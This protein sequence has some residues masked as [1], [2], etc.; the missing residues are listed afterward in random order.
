METSFSS[1]VAAA[2]EEEDVAAEADIEIEDSPEI[3]TESGN[4]KQ[5]AESS[6]RLD[7]EEKPDVDTSSLLGESE[8]E[9]PSPS[10]NSGK[11][12]K[13]GGGSFISTGTEEKIE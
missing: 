10:E 4:G 8:E 11:G 1:S 7:E 2:T 5:L 6:K 3:P 12:E 9:D 13:A